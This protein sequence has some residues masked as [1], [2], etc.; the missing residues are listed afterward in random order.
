MSTTLDGL[1]QASRLTTLPEIEALRDE[2]RRLEERCPDLTP[3][4]T[5]VWCDT[6]AKYYGGGRP[7]WLFTFRDGGELVG[8]APFAETRLGGL[9][10]LRFIG[11]GQ[12]SYSIADYQDLLAAEGREDE[13]VVVFCDELARKPAWDVV[14]LQELPSSSR[15]VGRLVASAQSRGWLTQLKPGSD[16]HLIPINGT[17]DSYKA[18]LSR[19]MRKLTAVAAERAASFITVSDDEGAVHAAMEE[20]FDLHT[21]RWRS[22]GMPG[23]FGTEQR[24]RFYHEVAARFAQQGMLRLSFLTCEDQTVAINFGFLRGGVQYHYATGFNPDPEWAHFNFG[25]VLGLQ[26]IKDAFE[27]GERCVDWTRGA[28]PYKKRFRTEEYFNQDLLVFRNRRARLH[29]RFAHQFARV[30]RGGYERLRRKL[31]TKGKHSRKAD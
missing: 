29:Y 12:G 31:A 19:R 22:V 11:S 28:H 7:F 15:T 1:V 4:S 23:I 25:M 5:W 16:I 9:R 2:W 30:A 8:I 27:R 13:I 21:R 20:L 10:L 26:V 24:R 17:W 14:H 18:T 6:A 3:F